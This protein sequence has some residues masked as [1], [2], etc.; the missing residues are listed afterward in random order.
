VY[1]QLPTGQTVP[2]HIPA[3]VLPVATTT[4]L[5]QQALQ[6]LATTAVAAQSQPVKLAT[7]QIETTAAPAAS[8]SAANSSIKQVW[9]FFLI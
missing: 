3:T 5:S 1:L 8:S 4:D 2:V 6:Q 7:R 9:I